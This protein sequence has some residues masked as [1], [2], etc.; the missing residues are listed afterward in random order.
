MGAFQ[1]SVPRVRRLIVEDA[2]LISLLIE[3]TVRELGHEPVACAYS[4]PEALS[5]LDAREDSIDAAM[6]DVNLGGRLVYP[7]AE[8]LEKRKIPFAFVTGYGTHGVPE[9][10]SSA[11]V[12]QKPFTEDDLASAC[13]ILQQARFSED[14]Q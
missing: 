11:A 4:V 13:A 5:V 10:F 2:T 1:D 14:R 7:V 9:R 12:M 6:L 3:T 8:A